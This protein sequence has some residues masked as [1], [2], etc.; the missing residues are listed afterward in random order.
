MSDFLKEVAI[1]VTVT[2]VVTAV[3]IGTMEYI[4]RPK[5][6]KRHA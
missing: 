2:L 3:V 5:E 6:E 1:R 4:N